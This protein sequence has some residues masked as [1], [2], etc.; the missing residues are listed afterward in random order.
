MSRWVMTTLEDFT[1][2]V[3]IYSIGNSHADRNARAL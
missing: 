3:E 1:P 2:N